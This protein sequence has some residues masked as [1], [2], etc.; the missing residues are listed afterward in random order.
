MTEH[1][2]SVREKRIPR[3]N[4]NI[5]PIKTWEELYEVFKRYSKP[6]PSHMS[7]PMDAH[8]FIK[9]ILEDQFFHQDGNV[10]QLML[11]WIDWGLFEYSRDYD[12]FPDLET[13]YLPKDA[14]ALDVQYFDGF[15][16]LRYLY[17]NGLQLDSLPVGIF[18]NLPVLE[19]LDLSKN[20]LR[21]LPD[22]LF[23]FNPKL[24]RIN[25]YSNRI[26]AIPEYIFAE[27]SSIEEL[28]FMNTLGIAD[29]PSRFFDDL[30]VIKKLELRGNRIKE[31]PASILENDKLAG[32]LENLELLI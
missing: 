14:G 30:P 31:L 9:D 17:L 22:E 2:R 1:Q 7:D 28:N 13:L 5:E 16:K 15:P 8:Y 25:F 27:N 12:K 32:L 23:Y 3:I 18:D 24:K 4:K 26:E 29:L 11:E 21:S 10:S 6:R 19:H 20:N